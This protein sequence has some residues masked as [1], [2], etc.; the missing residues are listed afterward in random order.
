MGGRVGAERTYD[1]LGLRQA[2]DQKVVPHCFTGFIPATIFVKIWICYY[3]AVGG[4]FGTRLRIVELP[5]CGLSTPTKVDCQTQES[6]EWTN[7]GV[8]RLVWGVVHS[9]ETS[10]GSLLDNSPAESQEVQEEPGLV[11][12]S[13]RD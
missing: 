11:S 8:N 1:E 12:C 9:P 5:V 13:T 6:I 2:I 4:A 3:D 10:N 7:D